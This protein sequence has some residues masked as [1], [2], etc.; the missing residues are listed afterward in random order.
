MALFYSGSATIDEQMGLRRADESFYK[1]MG[2]NIYGSIRSCIHPDD[3]HRFE[4]A[5]AELKDDK[6]V[7]N[8]VT[9]RK[10]NPDGTF[11]WLLI[12]LSKESFQ[13]SSNSLYHLNL[14]PLAREQEN[15]S[16]LKQLNEEYEA[17]FDLLSS[18]LLMYDVKTK[19]LDIFNNCDGQKISLFHGSLT[20]WQELVRPKL[21]P[22]YRDEFY[23]LCQ[24]MEAGN[25]YFKH[26][27][28]TNF[29]STDGSMEMCSFKCRTM[30]DGLNAGKVF[31]CITVL[32]SNRQDI[33]LNAGYSMD[34]GI[35]VLNKRSI[36]EYAK[37]S[38]LSASGQVHLIIL[39]LDDFKVINDTYGH[40]FGDEVLI[41]SA[42]IIK[43]VIG[44]SGIAGR[45]G[46]DE[47]MI[48]LNRIESHAEL[49]NMLRS[50]RTGIEWAYKNTNDDL[51]VT[52]S[53]GVATYPDHGDNYDKIFQLADRML[54]IAKNKGKNRYVIYTPELHEK[55]TSVEKQ[56]DQS[57]TT[58]NLRDDKTG[59][60]QRL[61]NEFL[62]RKIVPYSE[63]LKEIGYCFELDEIV[64]IY[65]DMKLCSIWSHEG[66]L[67]DIRNNSYLSLERGIGDS[68]DKDQILAI[69]GIF[70]LEEKAPVLSKVLKERGIESALFY[71]MS[72]N[73][74]TFGYIMFAKKNRRQMW[75]EYDKTLLATIGKIIEI[76][77]TG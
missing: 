23:A 50:I 8:I 32:G 3:F 57:N 35:P 55:N 59:V 54:Y 48:V 1:Y 76:S 46:G 36:T 43:E 74:T 34:I 30:A 37:K 72:K 47:L 49:R 52:C 22:E 5:L 67:S 66:Y 9:V 16:A 69:N 38:L 12:E 45:I 6:I 65:D 68:F 71:K 40:M 51:H 64:M 39:D 26:G 14:F 77:F 27:I 24:E 13:I 62:I 41:K 11:E 60:M 53:I 44:S 2:Q 25:S 63:A 42:N 18:T 29:F 61:V 20:E 56:A 4:N 10:M 31:G 75:S 70:N 19:L 17:L 28:M 7:R 33:S 73:G 15:V 21:E 58:E